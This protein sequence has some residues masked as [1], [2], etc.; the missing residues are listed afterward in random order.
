MG[1][2]RLVELEKELDKTSEKY[3]TMFLKYS[4]AFSRKD[5]YKDC[6]YKLRKASEKEK[7]RL[8]KQKQKLEESIV[9]W[10]TKAELEENRRLKLN[11]NYL[12][13]EQEI[14]AAE[15]RTTELMVELTSIRLKHDTEINDIEESYDK[16]IK[17]EKKKKKKKK[18]GGGKKKK[19][20]KKKK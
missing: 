12:Q 19:K 18:K 6:Y 8:E 15:G 16:L 4:F 14:E 13:S 2:K 3:R 1:T 17:E 7:E 10:K 5:E 20:K 11:I 9:K